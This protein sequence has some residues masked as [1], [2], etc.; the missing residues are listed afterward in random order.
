MGN[1]ERA[2]EIFEQLGEQSLS[3]KLL[4]YTAGEKFAK[5]GLCRLARNPQD[6]SGVLQ[7]ITEWE[8]T[9][10][11]FAGSRESKWLTKMAEACQKQD[12]DEFNEAI[13]VYQL[14]KLPKWEED[15][16]SNIRGRIGPDLR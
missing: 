12:V 10:P 11:A 14:A 9:C 6:S 2:E 13:R 16:L 4:K 7:K 15:I 8:E 5:A 3:N 1:F